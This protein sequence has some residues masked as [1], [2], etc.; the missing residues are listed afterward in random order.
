MFRIQNEDGQSQPTINDNTLI[1]NIFF[2]FSRKRSQFSD[3]VHA[4]WTV[5][6]N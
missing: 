2:S 1:G 6:V 4:L 3:Y 5:R